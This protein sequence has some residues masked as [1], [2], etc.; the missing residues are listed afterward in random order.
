MKSLFSLVICAT[1]ALGACSKRAQCPAYMDMSKGTLSVQET[2]TMSPGEIHEQSKKLLDSQ[3]S[4]I[5]VKRDPKTGLVKSKKRVKMGKNN[6]KMHKG[7]KSD[8][9]LMQGVK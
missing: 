5:A 3:D 2:K 4:Y 1:L 6:T 7:F 9:R 8:P